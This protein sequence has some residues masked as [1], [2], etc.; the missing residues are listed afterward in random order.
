M[1]RLLETF[2]LYLMLVVFAIYGVLYLAPR[3]GEVLS[4]RMIRAVEPEKH[5]PSL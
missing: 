2:I 4:E 5:K 1:S 3:V